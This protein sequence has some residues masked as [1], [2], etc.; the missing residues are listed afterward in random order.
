VLN[1]S[2]WTN[3]A[4][5]KPR[6]SLTMDNNDSLNRYS[7]PVT[8]SRTGLYDMGSLDQTNTTRFLFGDDE[9]A[10]QEPK[11]GRGVAPDDNFPTLVRRDDQ[12]VSQSQLT[13]L[14]P[15]Q[16]VLF[17]RSVLWGFGVLVAG[18]HVVNSLFWECFHML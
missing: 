18:S 14:L 16:L 13:R 11:Y 1:L 4:S 5:R 6:V 10:S 15:L 2:S 9:P 12:V 7:M 8:R 3:I 17:V